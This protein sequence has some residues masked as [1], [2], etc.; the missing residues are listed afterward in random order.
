[1]IFSIIILA[2]LLSFGIYMLLADLFKIPTLASDKA[3]IAFGKRRSKGQNN[4]IFNVM[5][6][7]LINEVAKV[8]KLDDFKHRKISTTLQ[9]ADMFCTPEFYIANAIVRSG[10]VMLLVIPSMLIFPIL[11]FGVPILSVLVYFKESARADEIVRVQREEIE[12]ELPRFCATITQELKTRRDILSILESYRVHSGKYMNRELSIT[13]A[14]MKSGSYESALTRFEARIGSTD[15][16]NIVRGLISVIRGDDGY[17]YFQLL[18]HDLENLELHRLKM[19]AIKQPSKVRK[20]SYFML[21]CM[22]LIYFG[23]MA[24]QIITAKDGYMF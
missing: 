5:L 8:I 12:H 7:N 19:I 18:S 6:T 13:I 23:L 20:Y 4:Q 1:M 17:V 21:F 16:S 22:L 24:I 15:L 11:A 2:S 9:S 10:L 14:D 3:I